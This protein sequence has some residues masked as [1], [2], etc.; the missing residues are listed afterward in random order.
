MKHISTNVCE[1]SIVDQQT[2][3]LSIINCI[4][5]IHLPKN[6]LEARDKDGSIKLPLKIHV[7]S[8]WERQGREDEKAKIKIEIFTPSGEKMNDFIHD[9][10]IPVKFKKMRDRINVLGFLIK[11]EGTYKI[12]LSKA[13]G[14]NKFENVFDTSVEILFEK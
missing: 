13:E 8:L 14:E 6:L 2:N 3:Q 12:I 10:S 9:L 1:Q 5:E 11:E 4:E 7:V